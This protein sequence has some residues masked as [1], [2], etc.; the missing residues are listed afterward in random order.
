MSSA[1]GS[2][3]SEVS[4]SSGC[5]GQAITAPRERMQD[6]NWRHDGVMMEGQEIIEVRRITGSNTARTSTSGFPTTRIY[7]DTATAVSSTGTQ[8]YSSSRRKISKSSQ[9]CSLS[10]FT[11][12]SLE[13]LLLYRVYYVMRFETQQVDVL[14]LVIVVNWLYSRLHSSRSSHRQ[15][16]IHH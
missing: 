15:R 16:Q 7:S 8:Q 9:I 3:V 10:R 1:A 2:P 5:R 12:P 13:P 14:H 6:D 11:S 4:V